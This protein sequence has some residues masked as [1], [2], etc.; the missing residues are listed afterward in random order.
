[1]NSVDY[2]ALFS[3]VNSETMGVTEKIFLW[4]AVKLVG[5]WVGLRLKIKDMQQL[6]LNSLM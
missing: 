2:A 5:H 4:P 1:M 3:F 6:S